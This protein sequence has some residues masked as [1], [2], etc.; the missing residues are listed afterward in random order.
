MPEAADAIRTMRVRGAAAIAC[1]GATTLGHHV[2][3]LAGGLPAVHAGARRAAGILFATRPTAVSLRNGLGAVL[4]PVLA[5][6]DADAARAEA[7]VAANAFVAA[8]DASGQAIAEHGSSLLAAGGAVL[9]HCHSTTVIDVLR[10]AQ[11]RGADLHVY[12]TETR[13]FRQGLVTVRALHDGGVPCTL[14]VDSAVSHVLETKAIRWV[15]VG[16]DTVAADGTL[17]NKVGTAGV[18]AL[19][20][21]RGVPVHSAAGFYK[22]T[23]QPPGAIPIEERAPSEVVPD[24]DVPPGVAVFNPVFDRTA[25]GLLTSYITEAGPRTPGEAVRQALGRLPASEALA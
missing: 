6:T 9:T 21:R 19:A 4:A 3:G 17:F 15:L 7:P 14:I 5:A 2:A 20:Q 11:A 22:F 10:R 12:A 24:S 16:A 25:P 8:V 18:C 13:P 23:R 1:L